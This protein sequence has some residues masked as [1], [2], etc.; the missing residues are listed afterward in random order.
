MDVMAG[1]LDFLMRAVPR[2]A[3]MFPVRTVTVHRQRSA[4]PHGNNSLAS[5]GVRCTVGTHAYVYVGLSGEARR[6]KP[7]DLGIDQRVRRR[8]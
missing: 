8:F 2:S 4:T 5:L 1:N 3:R 6:G 7:E